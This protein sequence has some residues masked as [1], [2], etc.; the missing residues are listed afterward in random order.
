[1]ANYSIPSRA[2][3]AH[4]YSLPEPSLKGKGDILRRLSSNAMP[5]LERK[6]RTG[7][8]NKNKWVKEKLSSSPSVCGGHKNVGDM[9][10]RPVRQKQSVLYR[11]DKNLVSTRSGSYKSVSISSSTSTRRPIRHGPCVPSF[12]AAFAHS[13]VSGFIKI[14]AFSLGPT[15]PSASL[16]LLLQLLS[17]TTRSN[18]CII[19]IAGTSTSVGGPVTRQICEHIG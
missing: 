12:L 6:A 17:L 19:I 16:W 11:I 18:L 13:A 5:C 10:Y 1:M 3:A 7:R 14:H 4:I 15:Y 2:V 8:E 9:Y